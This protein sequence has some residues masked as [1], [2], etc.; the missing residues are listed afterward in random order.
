MAIFGTKLAKLLIKVD[1]LEQAYEDLMQQYAELKVERNEWRKKYELALH[2]PEYKLNA[3]AAYGRG[4]AQA[5][6][7]MK[8]N[9]M[10]FVDQLPKEEDKADA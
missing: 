4:Y 2:T 7:N 1:T 10:V 6:K 8:N 3:E 5:I 9:L